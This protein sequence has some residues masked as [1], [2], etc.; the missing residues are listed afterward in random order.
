MAEPSARR[1]NPTSYLRPAKALA[2]A[3]VRLVGYT[4]GG[5]RETLVSLTLLA[6]SSVAAGIL[7]GKNTDRL[8]EL[9]GLLLMVPAA[10]ALR[11]NIFGAAG[12]RLG[13]A[14]HAGTYRMSFRPSSVVGENV[15]GSLLLNL[16]LSL[17]L[18]GMGSSFATVFGV[19]DSISL[20]EFVV[21]SVTGG[22]LAS[23]AVLGVTLLLS[24]LSVRYG[25]DPDNVTVPL[26][27]SAADAITLPA[28]FVAIWFFNIDRHADWLAPVYLG[29]AVAATG[30]VWSLGA[31]QSLRRMLAESI[32]VLVVAMGFDLF[33]G[34]AVESR[35]DKLVQ[36]PSL[37][38]L[39]P[40]YLAVAG[41]LGSILSSRLSTK[42]HLGVVT[43]SRLPNA[44]AR[45]DLIGLA[46]LAL[47]GYATLALVVQVAAWLFGVAG[48]GFAELVAVVLVGGVLVVALIT[49]VAYYG[50]MASV[51]VG[52]NPDTYGVPIIT[53]V[54]DLVGAFVLVL[55]IDLLGVV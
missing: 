46:V 38:V 29:V 37:L 26:V 7:L 23:V 43:P 22:V 2:R 19:A 20:S 48:P 55:A 27:T 28:L 4:K 52:V 53:A 54:L 12:A 5:A 40:G 33:A 21:I 50:T 42:L 30:L 36:V 49:T 16:V 3:I 51:R 35:L 1:P 9:P 31:N 11:G 47:P 32:P 10:I 41:S 24:M 15:I 39:L 18:A 14:I 13:T 25:W 44:P 34:I 45:A 17:V 8:A 6:V